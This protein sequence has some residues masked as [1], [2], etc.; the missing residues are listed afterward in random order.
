[1]LHDIIDDIINIR[2]AVRESINEETET[3]TR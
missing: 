1:M 3:E 2:F